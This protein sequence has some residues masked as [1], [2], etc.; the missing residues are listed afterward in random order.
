[1]FN[2]SRD[3]ARRFLVESWRKRRDGMPASAI[4]IMAG[5]II[6]L[7]PEYHALLDGTMESVSREWSP[8]D[9]GTNPFLHLSLHLAIEEQLSID[10]PPGI[11]AAFE[12][13]RKRHGDRHQALHA[14]LDALAETLWRSQ[15][16]NAPLDGTTYLELLRRAGA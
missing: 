6:A 14:V 10:Q 4:E 12:Q 7:H 3:Q 9:G 2:P 5:D 13:L 15:R 11:V 16:D 8:D 1:M